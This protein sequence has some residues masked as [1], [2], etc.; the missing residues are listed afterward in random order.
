MY[1][2][3]LRIPSEWLVFNNYFDRVGVRG[4]GMMV[5]QRDLMSFSGEETCCW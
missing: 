5:C 4:H 2:L 3:A 1:C